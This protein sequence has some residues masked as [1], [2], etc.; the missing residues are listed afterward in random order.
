M[1]KIAALIGAGALLLSVSGIVF[2]RGS[3]HQSQSSQPLI[4]ADVAVVTTS[5]TAVA[6]TG[7]NTQNNNT[8]VDKAHEVEVE[9]GGSRIINTG[10]ADA[11]ATTVVVANTRVGC[12]N[13][14]G[15]RQEQA[16]ISGYLAVVDSTSDARAYTGTN[17]QDDNTSVT[18]AHEVEVETGEGRGSSRTI[19]TS[20]SDADALSL[21]VVNTRWNLAN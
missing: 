9:N 10:A 5:S 16:K 3:R 7:L 11:D 18:N 8:L 14:G 4:N 15:R 20:P 13:C 6:D 12:D 2:A 21:T 17:Q 19:N 1:K